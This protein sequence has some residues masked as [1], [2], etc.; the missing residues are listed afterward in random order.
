MQLQRRLAVS[1]AV[2]A[3]EVRDGFVCTSRLRMA[4]SRS[5]RAVLAPCMA[6]P[7][8]M[9]TFVLVGAGEE[10]REDLFEVDSESEI[11]G[12]EAEGGALD[13]VA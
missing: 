9:F 8:E 4:E 13:V 12:P 6:I 5:D 7:P 1:A 2:L 10:F 3:F 11:N